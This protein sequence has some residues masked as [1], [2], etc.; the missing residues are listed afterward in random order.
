MSKYI[1]PDNKK[2][3]EIQQTMYTF[4]GSRYKY[5][6]RH[7]AEYAAAT[8]QICECGKEFEGTSYIFCP[9]CREKRSN[10]RYLKLELV[11]WD[12]EIP[13]MI[14]DTDIYFFSE[15]DIYNYCEDS[16]VEV[17][18]QDLQL[19]VCEPNRPAYL[20]LNDYLEDILPEDA[21]A[22]ELSSDL[23]SAEEIE[24]I[25]NDWLKAVSP[26]SWSGGSKRVILEGGWK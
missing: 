25:V 10:E 23:Y 21:D 11:K 12:S 17:K 13:L 19:V 15:D 18:I 16:E 22:M 14:W 2:I 24:T 7:T 5:Q 4:D 26:I 6:D 1:L 20:D 8:G 3:R 9:E